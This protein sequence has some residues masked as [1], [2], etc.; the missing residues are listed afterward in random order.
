MKIDD[1]LGGTT[2][3]NVILKFPSIVKE[4]NDSDEFD[5]WEEENNKKEEKSKYWFTRDKMDKIIKV[6]DYLTHYLKLEKF[7]RLVQ[8]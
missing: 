3:L 4:S 6:H 1:E 5:E 2:P 7:Y 8:S